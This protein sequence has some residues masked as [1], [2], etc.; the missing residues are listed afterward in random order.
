MPVRDLPGYYPDIQDG[1]LG[2]LPPSLAG[3]FCIVG[4][5]EKGSTGVKFAFN[6]DDV[7]DEYGYGSILE[8]AMDAFDAGARQIGIVRAIAD[9]VAT[10]ITT[11]VHKIY[12]DPTGGGEATFTVGLVSPHTV[13]GS[14]RRFIIRIVQAG[15]FST[16]TYQVS[17]N[18]GISFGPETR[19]VT[20]T[21]G[22]P[23]K[24]KIDMGN[25]TYIEFSEAGTA[26]DSFAAGD[27]YHWW[28][29]E[30]RA[31]LGEIIA[32]CE[33]AIAWKDSN[34]GQGFEYIYESILDSNTWGARTKTNIT[35]LWGA[36]ITLADTLWTEEQRPVFFG[37]DAPGMLPLKDA[38]S[39]E[40]LDDWIDLLVS[41]SAEKR[42]ERLWVNAGQMLAVDN[43]GDIQVRMAGGSVSGLMSASKLHHSIG[44]V[45]TMDIPNA[46]AV[47]PFKPIF[48]VDDESLGT[49]DGSKKTFTGFLAEAPV[50]PWAVTITSNDTVPEVFVDGGDGILYDSISG[51]AA[52]TI[53]YDTGKYSV[54]FATAPAASKIVSADYHYVTADEMDKGRISLLNDARFITMR[55]WI[56]YG[57]RFTDD[58]MMAPATSD[59]FCIRNRRIVD[60]AVRQ[61]GIANTPYVN[62]PGI[63]PKDMAAYKADLARPLDAMKITETDT[64]K[65]IMDY[66]ITLTPDDNVWSNGTIHAKVEIVPTPTKKRLEAVFVLKTKVS[67]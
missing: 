41:C 49:G 4:T 48:D 39:L 37:V 42:D 27:E 2:V 51:T 57:I 56:G 19:F 67:E 24:S 5:S 54:T 8:K 20:T 65:P 1:G 23:N 18:N 47:Y 64:D 45:R 43:R 59:Y 58:F 30:P 3:L 62:S 44:L 26:A 31:T 6:A 15:A 33:R 50:V 53:D 52:G 28:T 7:L 36:L 21:P 22:T 46:I 29:Y 32:A 14:N 25:G 38:D 16:A 61:V 60:E 9:S 63:A 10:P 13:V 34:T 11:P 55:H 40:E 35:A 12:G 66:K 17:T